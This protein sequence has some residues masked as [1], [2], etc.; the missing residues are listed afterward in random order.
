MLS[1][2]QLRK[3]IDGASISTKKNE[4]YEILEWTKKKQKSYMKWLA[5]WDEIPDEK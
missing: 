2:K 3:L 5:K 1:K 4:R